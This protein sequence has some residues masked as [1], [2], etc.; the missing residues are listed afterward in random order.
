MEL[1]IFSL[2]LEPP[3]KLCNSLDPKDSLSLVVPNVSFLDMGIEVSI[4]VSF[5]SCKFLIPITNSSSRLS[6]VCV[7][8]PIVYHYFGAIRHVAWDYV[9]DYLENSDV[10][11]SSYALFGAAT[12]VSLGAMLL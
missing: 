8:F 3:W 9:P 1:L 10:E 4:F 11:K 12:V 6:K 7:T 2:V 5:R